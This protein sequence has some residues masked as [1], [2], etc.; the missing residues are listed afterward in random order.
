VTRRLSQP[1][2]RYE[3]MSNMICHETKVVVEDREGGHYGHVRGLPPSPL[4]THSALV[5]SNTHELTAENFDLSLQH[6]QQP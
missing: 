2:P 4:D 1:R 5:A 6:L 3:K